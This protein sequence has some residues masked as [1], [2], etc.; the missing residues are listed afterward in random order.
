MIELQQSTKRSHIIS[1]AKGN[2]Y[3]DEIKETLPVKK[4]LPIKG[5]D[6]VQLKPKIASHTYKIP[7][8]TQ[9]KSRKNRNLIRD[10]IESSIAITLPPHKNG[11]RNYSKCISKRNNI[12]V[13]YNKRCLLSKS[14]QFQFFHKEKNDFIQKIID[15]PLCASKTFSKLKKLDLSY[16]QVLRNN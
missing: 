11:S 8:K 15:S 1:N 13:H 5:E 14:E 7:S 12:A 10:T 3:G 16:A 2:T 4:E 6:V 9:K